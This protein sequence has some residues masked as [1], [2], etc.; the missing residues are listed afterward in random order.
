MVGDRRVAASCEGSISEKIRAPG[1]DH[2][3]QTQP[4]VMFLTDPRGSTWECR[5]RL[6]VGRDPITSGHNSSS[7]N[8]FCPLWNLSLAASEALQSLPCRPIMQCY[9]S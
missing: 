9:W 2:C 5:Q 1:K 4:S 8:T 6:Q 7:S 3:K